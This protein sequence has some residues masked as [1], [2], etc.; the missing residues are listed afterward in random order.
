MNYE[1]G[2][3]VISKPQ[4][5][6]VRGG[7][8]TS[9]KF[10]SSETVS[11]DSEST[12]QMYQANVEQALCSHSSNT[13]VMK[14][15]SGNKKQIFTGN[16]N[17]YGDYQA[18]AEKL[19]NLS[20][21]KEFHRKSLAFGLINSCE[22]YQEKK[23]IDKNRNPDSFLHKTSDELTHE[24]LKNNHAHVFDDL[25]AILNNNNTISSTRIPLK[26]M[27]LDEE[28]ITMAPT[29][30]ER[31]HAEALVFEYAKPSQSLP[32]MPRK[33]SS[34]FSM[35]VEDSS[36]PP[37]LDTQQ[38]VQTAPCE[39]FK[40]KKLSESNL[41]HSLDLHCI[42]LSCHLEQTSNTSVVQPIPHCCK[43][44]SSIFLKLY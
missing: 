14:Q 12:E 25:P 28:I 10:S 15:V 33:R 22:N 16:S 17:T 36:N 9:S 32:S 4:H 2:D 31:P 20:W 34:E 44:V 37:V 18:L 6:Q 23:S 24:I 41:A 19:T 1:S 11:Q 35:N 30:D 38:Q 39:D 7:A 13:D 21:N 8:W 26:K 40:R 3:G 43:Q 29:T 42:E 5:C 27:N